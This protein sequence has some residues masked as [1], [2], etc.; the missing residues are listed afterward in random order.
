MYIFRILIK[1][2]VV[3]GPITKL[4]FYEAGR[5]LYCH[6]RKT[7][8]MI[9]VLK[10]SPLL[11]SF[12]YLKPNVCMLRISII[13]CI[14]KNSQWHPAPVLLPRKSHGQRSLVGCSPWGR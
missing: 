13:C 12:L 11:I 5:I 3:T 7:N 14:A 10:F 8:D 4:T 1:D 6:F 2:F 9:P